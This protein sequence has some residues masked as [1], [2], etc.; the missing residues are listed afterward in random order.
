ML[1][2]LLLT[3]YFRESPG[4][5]LHGFQ[6]AGATVLRPFE[7]AAERVARP[8]RDAAGW[9][10]DVLDAKS[11]NEK[12]RR[13]LDEWRQRAIEGQFAQEDLDQLRRLLGYRSGARF[14]T[15]YRAVAAAVI[16]RAPSQ[17]EQ[18][19]VVAAGSSDGIR[20]HAPVVTP[21]GLVGRVTKVA[22]HAAQVT[23]L[24]DESSFVAALDLQTRADGLVRHGQ[25]GTS[26][27][28]L[29][30]VSK[31]QVVEPGNAIVTAGW[32]SDRFSSIY[33]RGIPIGVVTHVNQLD[34]DL[35]KQVQ[36]EP[37]VDFGSLDSVI[38][39]VSKKPEPVI[40]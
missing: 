17:Y 34:T 1:S 5:G 39:L 23:L 37:F 2:L 13:E 11:E 40:P 8:F 21:D 22:R 14:P 31:E 9:A 35:Y 32:K 33:P 4:G 26:S 29:D 16:A 38:V 19:I 6:S 30:R 24:T 7:V 28:K 3:V 12:L 18:Q 36:I 27:L 10:G 15:D 20:Q 25:Q